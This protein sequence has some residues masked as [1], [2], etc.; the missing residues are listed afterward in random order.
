MKHS[1][2]RILTTH[3]GSLP[4]PP[5][6]TRLY[7]RRVRGEAVDPKAIEAEG[8]AALLGVIPK[9]IE[10]G[11]DI[12]NNGEQ[13]RESF[14]LYLRHRLSGLGDSSSRTGWADL[15]AYPDYKQQVKEL[16]GKQEAVTNTDFLPAAIGEVRYLDPAAVND[17]CTDFRQALAAHSGSYAEAFLTAPSPGII[18]SIVQNRHYDS[19]EAYLAALGD[20]L[21]VE[22][23]AIVA[24]GFLLQLDC[25]DLALERHCSYRDRPLSDFLGFCERVIT[26]INRAIANIPRDRVRLHVCWGNYEGPHDHDVPLEDILPI[27]TQAKVG[28]FVLP[29]A[30]PRH[31]HE[32]KVFAKHPLAEDQILV[33]GVLDTTTN[34]IEHP[35][36]IADRIERVAQVMGDP[37]RVQAGTDCGFDT[38]AGRGRVANDVVWAK[39]KSMRQ[40]SEIASARLFRG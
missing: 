30:N 12:I 19:E 27:V 38:S 20:A 37:K 8:R 26:A 40:G 3:T 6:L 25:P 24:Q 9:Q 17:E 11:L 14:V 22:Y 2:T 16:A 32:Y 10:S 34:F 1:E 13:Q 39:L 23:E 7:A 31:A 5:A 18:G 35:E 15:D 21:R 28:G 29:F 36:V 4:R 33:A